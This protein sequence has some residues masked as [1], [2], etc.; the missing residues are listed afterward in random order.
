MPEQASQSTS[1][2]LIQ[3]VKVRDESAWTR[4]THL[5]GPLVYQWSRRAGLKEADIKDVTQNVY[6]VISSSIET[7]Q[8][9]QGNFRAWL[10]GITRNKLR[11]FYRAL[12][13]A[14]GLGGP[15]AHEML[16]QIPDD[17]R[18]WEETEE[19][20]SQLLQRALDLIQ[21]E[22]EHHTWQAFWRMTI[23]GD[24]AKDVATD[25]GISTVAVR[26]AK[27]RILRRLRLELDDPEIF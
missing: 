9:E 4:L 27:F 6:I 12:P 14:R 21:P 18:Q 22:F 3:R 5:Y 15:T 16:Q 17:Y 7:Y 20:E 2:S 24:P 8:P 11:E 25:L 26:Q 10:W 13:E 1:L 19:D 23:R